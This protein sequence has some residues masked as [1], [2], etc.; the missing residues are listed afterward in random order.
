MQQAYTRHSH[1]TCQGEGREQG[2]RGNFKSESGGCE[3]M[4]T[5]RNLGQRLILMLH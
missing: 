5:G 3:G 4:Q 1:S 2:Q